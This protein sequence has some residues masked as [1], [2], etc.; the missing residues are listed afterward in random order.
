MQYAAELQKLCS[1]YRYPKM[2]NG[3]NHKSLVQLVYLLKGKNMITC[4]G[5]IQ[6]SMT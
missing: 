6:G 1:L 3:K 5:L 2:G 4:V